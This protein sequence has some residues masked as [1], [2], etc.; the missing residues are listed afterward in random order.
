VYGKSLCWQI[1]QLGRHQIASLNSQ[2]LARH[3]VIASLAKQSGLSVHPLTSREV[4]RLVE[5]HGFVFD[6]QKGSHAVYR[7][8]DGRR[9]TIPMHASRTM[10]IG[11]LRQILRDAE[12]APDELRK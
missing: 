2:R 8:A 11:L 7:H 5:T 1:Q 6:R 12:I 9:V 10:G 4:V 3:S